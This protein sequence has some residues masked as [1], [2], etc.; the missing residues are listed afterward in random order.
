LPDVDRSV[1]LQLQEI[2][3]DLVEKSREAST[4]RPEVFFWKN[5]IID[6]TTLAVQSLYPP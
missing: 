5:S 6:A 3:G 4:D 2:A 1:P